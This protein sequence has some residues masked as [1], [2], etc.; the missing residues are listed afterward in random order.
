MV[1]EEGELCLDAPPTPRRILASHAVDQLA[2]RG[3]N[4]R[5]THPVRGG[6]PAPVELKALAAPGDDGRGP[7]DDETGA[8]PRPEAGQPDPKDPVPASEPGSADRALKHPELVAEREI[9][10]GDGRRPEEHGAQ[11]RPETGHEEH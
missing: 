5:A 7:N 2:D 9:L 3:I 11:E 8:P 4:L 1:A 10:E 6:P